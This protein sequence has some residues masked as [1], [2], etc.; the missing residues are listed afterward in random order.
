MLGWSVYTSSSEEGN[1]KAIAPFIIW[2]APRLGKMNQILHCDWLPKRARWSY[3]A[4]SGLLA[5]SRK[6]SLSESHIINP[7]L[8]N[9]V[10]SRWQILALFFFLRVYGPWQ[11]T[12][13]GP[14]SNHLDLTLGQWPILSRN[15]CKRLWSCSHL[16]TLRSYDAFTNPWKK[17]SHNIHIQFTKSPEF[18]KPISIPLGGSKN[19]GSILIATNHL[20]QTRDN[21]KLMIWK[22]KS[23]NGT[24]S[25]GIGHQPKKCF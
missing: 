1:T 24:S 15:L 3:L 22:T 17:R 5:M 9:P 6:K 7:L 20:Q 14:I 10:R 8:T 19:G 18:S 16:H 25:E 21:E 4:R 2:L 23:I 11:H 13:T 12:I